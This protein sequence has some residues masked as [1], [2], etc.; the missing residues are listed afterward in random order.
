MELANLDRNR[1]YTA[2]EYFCWDFPERVELIK[3]KVYEVLPA[4]SPYHQ[5]ISG[6]IFIALEHFL[7]NKPCDV[8]YA[9]IDVYLP[10]NS[11]DDTV[12]Q[13]D[14]CVICDLSKIQK[15]GCV[16]APDIVVE[17]LSPGN[18][19]KEMKLK[20]NVYE[21][22]GVKEYWVVSPLYQMLQV[23]ILVD[24]KFL[25]DPVKTTGDLVTS[26]LLPGFAL[27][28]GELFKNTPTYED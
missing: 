10:G 3:G 15:K 19:T 11:K 17:I 13:P 2:S 20:F 26:S 1:T 16:G 6:G 9:P 28:L 18:S 27:D 4:P 25:Q 24:G 5:K 12:L 21:E 8:Y 7:R 23:Y 14:I 22:A